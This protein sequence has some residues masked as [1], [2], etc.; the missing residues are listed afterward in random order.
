MKKSRIT[1]REAT[2]A[3]VALLASMGRQTFHDT[4]AAHVSPDDMAAFLRASF[5]PEEQAAELADPSTFFLIAQEGNTPVGYAKLQAGEP[6]IDGV[7]SPA[8]ELARIYLLPEWIGRGVGSTLMQAG[9]DEAERRGFEV[10][11]LGVWEKNPRAIAFYRRWGFAEAGTK[12]FRLG[13]ERHTD[14]VMQRQVGERHT[15]QE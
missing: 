1:V 8:V 3:D 5:G 14:V 2:D 7:A 10:M 4:Y 15:V 12:R 9:L 11:W 6:P 13:A